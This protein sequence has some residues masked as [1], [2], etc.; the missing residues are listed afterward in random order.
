MLLY[1]P[2]FGVI[3]CDSGTV[4]VPRSPALFNPESFVLHPSVTLTAHAARSSNQHTLTH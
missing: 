1:V 4:F 2:G 3:L